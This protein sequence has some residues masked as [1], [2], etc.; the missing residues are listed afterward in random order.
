MS[1]DC[2]T[3]E[4]RPAWRDEFFHDRAALEKY[5]EEHRAW[6]RSSSDPFERADVEL[7]SQVSAPDACAIFNRVLESLARFEATGELEAARAADNKARQ[8]AGMP[9]LTESDYRVR[10]AREF[11]QLEIF[12][13]LPATEV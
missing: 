2:T 6:Q 4:T 8:A 7:W 3:N 13:L 5:A 9:V 1:S 12:K 11:F 10:F